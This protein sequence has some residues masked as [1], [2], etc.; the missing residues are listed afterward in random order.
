M[1]LTDMT[2]QKFKKITKEFIIPFCIMVFW[3]I[4][5]MLFVFPWIWIPLALYDE[6]WEGPKWTRYIA[7]RAIGIDVAWKNL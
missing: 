6:S 1:I 4:V 7:S 2:F 3:E 5:F